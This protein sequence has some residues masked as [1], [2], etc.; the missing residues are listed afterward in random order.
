MKPTRSFYALIEALA[1]L[2]TEMSQ[3]DSEIDYIPYERAY[4][5]GFEEMKRRCPDITKIKDL[6][7][8]EPKVDLRGIIRS[9]IDYYKK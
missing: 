4:G 7:G 3:R 8:F 2:D 6:I 1:V 5:S 9:V